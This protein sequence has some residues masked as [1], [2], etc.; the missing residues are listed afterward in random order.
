MFQ[1]IQSYNLRL[2][3]SNLHAGKAFAQITSFLSSERSTTGQVWLIRVADLTQIL[4]DNKK[5]P[6]FLLAF[7]EF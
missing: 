2:T 4:A 3:I 6:A 7:I 1:V 5:R